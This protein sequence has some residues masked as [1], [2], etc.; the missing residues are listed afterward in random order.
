MTRVDREANE[1]TQ[2]LEARFPIPKVKAAA[3]PLGERSHF[4]PN[5][6]FAL[7]MEG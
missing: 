1:S 3:N 2:A 5:L 6:R 7:T 4:G